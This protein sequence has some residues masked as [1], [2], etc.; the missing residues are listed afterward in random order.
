MAGQ[1]ADPWADIGQGAQVIKPATTKPTAPT[2]QSPAS[3]P[4]AGIG[5]GSALQQTVSPT[6]SYGASQPDNRYL[7]GSTPQGA[8][9]AVVRGAGPNIVMEA[10]N[11]LLP[12]IWNTAAMGMDALTPFVN[13]LLPPQFQQL[14]PSQGLQVLLSWLGV[15]KPDSEA[16]KILQ[17]ASSGLSASKAMADAGGAMAAGMQAPNT[18]Q[19]VGQVLAQ[20]P[21]QNMV[22]GTLGGA[23]AQTAASEGL[24]WWAQAAAGLGGSVVGAAGTGAVQTAQ[25]LGANLPRTVAEQAVNDANSVGGRLMTSDVFPAKPGPVS[26]L[27]KNLSEKN[28]LYGTGGMRAEQ[29]GQRVDAIKTLLSDYGATDVDHAS[30]AVMADLAQR[31]GDELSRL[32]QQK[33]SVIDKLSLPTLGAPASA[34]PATTTG[35]AQGG[36]PSR[37]VPMKATN[38]ALDNAIVYLQQ[39]KTDSVKPA[40]A[41]LQDWKSAIDGQ[42]LTNIEALRK[43]I[44]EDFKAPDL[45]STRSTVDKRLSEIYGAV[46]QD[47]GDYIKTVGGPQDYLQWKSA[48][49][50]L[51]GM[52]DE[53]NKGTLATILRTG[54]A[55]PEVVQRLLFSSKP[56]DVAALYK[57]LSPE[58]RISAQAAILSRAAEGAYTSG[59]DNISPE[60]FLTQVQKLGGPLGIFFEGAD[61]ARIEG[62]ARYL[63]LT[64]R[65]S[66]ANLNPQTGQQLLA[67]AMLSGS[68]AGLTSMLGG[69][70]Y[71]GAAATAASGLGLGL[72]SRAYESAPVRDALVKLSKAKAG[73][74]DEG[75]LFK[76]IQQGLTAQEA[77][78]VT[79]SDLVRAAQKTGGN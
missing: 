51:H 64:R 67:P 74:F 56:S 20:Q 30:A 78:T 50:Q 11:P 24:P 5:G 54:E 9:G 1:A 71:L 77:T 63:N 45:A 41:K 7:A 38:Q 18:T 79:N 34:G 62:L 40:I 33:N 23:A 52:A 42:D 37:V 14:P 58:G 35:L 22:G 69:D 55:T 43:Q 8:L 70:P 39:L 36:I 57:N 47:M 72:L 31:R 61:K 3:D 49:E 75:S 73:S 66:Q 68:G 6:S 21:V 2:A 17:V 48:N 65:A 44:G 46:N 16:A 53:L 13:K 60:K 15:A 25:N 10:V 76:R 19:R 28:P 59:T 32:S 4:W 12:V 26:N 29:Q 27:Y